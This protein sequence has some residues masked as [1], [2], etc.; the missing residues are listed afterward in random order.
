MFAVDLERMDERAFALTEERDGHRFLR[1]AEGRC[2]ALSLDHA[3]SHV[4]CSIYEMRPDVCRWLERGS[5]ECRSQLES[6]WA[7]REAA[8]GRG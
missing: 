1:F 5:G 8:F 3:N 7:V 6:K 4:G 2:A